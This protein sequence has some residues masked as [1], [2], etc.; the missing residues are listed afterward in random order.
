MSGNLKLDQLKYGTLN[1]LSPA[2][3][4]D[5]GDRRRT[6]NVVAL[7]NAIEA[8]YSINTTLGVNEYNGIVVYHKDIE[9][10]TYQDRTSLL[11]EYV[12]QS[13]ASRAEN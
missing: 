8:A 10:A 11:Q 7:S 5:S 13:N 3:Q 1:D 9:Y 4:G 12:V 6:T 2:P